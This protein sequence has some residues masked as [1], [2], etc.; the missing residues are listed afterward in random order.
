MIDFIKLKIQNP[1]IQ[2]IHENPLLEWNQLTNECTGQ[3]KEY[4]AE[5]HGLT[6]RITVNKYLSIS[7]SLHK[8]WNSITGRGLQNYN[9][10]S[11]ND[12]TKTVNT[13]CQSFNLDSNQ[14]KLEN[15]EFGVNIT[16]TIPANKILKAVINHRLQPF[17]RDYSNNKRFREAIHRQYFIKIYNKGLQYEQPK[18]ILRFEVKVIKMEFLKNFGITTLSDII[19]NDK[20]ISLGKEL[21]DNFRDVLFYGIDLPVNSLNLNERVVLSEGRNPQNWIDLKNGN[22]NTYNQRR[23]RFI[24]L[25]TRYSTFNISENI[26]KMITEKWNE[27]QF[28][29]P[30]I[31]HNLTGGTIPHY[32]QLDP[33]HDRSNCVTPIFKVENFSGEVLIKTNGRR[34]HEQH[35]IPVYHF[36]TGKLIE[37][38]DLETGQRKQAA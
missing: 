14:C 33:L 34:C 36:S 32:T 8:H 18:N 7:G 3:I 11:F 28:K 30:E 1:D 5:Y 26:G 21:R 35:L 24:E 20:L 17:T 10:F 16:P 9:D 12:L 2:A 27:L 29:L 38:L 25:V 31:I 4:T 19:D 23:K 37:Y 6:F 15:V 13:L 22:R